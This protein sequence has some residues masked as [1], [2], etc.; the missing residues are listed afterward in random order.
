M[1]ARDRH[2]VAV[3]SVDKICKNFYKHAKEIRAGWVPLLD[4]GFTRE[5]LQAHPSIHLWVQQHTFVSTHK[6]RKHRP[7]DAALLQSLPKEP[8][9]DCVKSFRK[10]NLAH[11]Q[12]R[13]AA[14]AAG[15]DKGMPGGQVPHGE[16]LVM[17][18]Q[19]THEAGLGDMACARERA[20]PGIQPPRQDGHV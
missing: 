9:R 11:V 3:H 12:R 1:G 8:T 17:R 4:A 14:R 7:M 18:A 19:A 2:A 16:L 10:V 13:G 6:R 20:R 15:T 5:R